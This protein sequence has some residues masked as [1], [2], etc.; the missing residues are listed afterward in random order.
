MECAE[1]LLAFLGSVLLGEEQTGLVG[2]QERLSLKPTGNF[3]SPALPCLD[4]VLV[5]SRWPVKAE[6]FSRKDSSFNEAALFSRG[7][8]DSCPHTEDYLLAAFSATMEIKSVQ[9]EGCGWH[10]TA[11]PY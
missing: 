8:S 4:K 3:R 10:G 5:A 2:H 1:S 6:G 11:L 7:K 9:K